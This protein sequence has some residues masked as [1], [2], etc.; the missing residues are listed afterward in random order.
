M[1]QYSDSK[2]LWEKAT[3]DILYTHYQL[4]HIDKMEAF[5]LSEPCLPSDLG[6]RH[7]VLGMTVPMSKNVQIHSGLH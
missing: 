4:L 3:E 7:Q 2:H 1:L 6:L 5:Y